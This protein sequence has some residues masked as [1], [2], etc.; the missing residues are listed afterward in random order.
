MK[1]RRAELTAHFEF[2]LD[3]FQLRALDALDDGQS[4]LVAA[5]TGSGKTVVA[6]YAIDA[7]IADGHRAFYTA[8][9]KALSNQKYHDLATRLGPQ[10]VGLLTGD[11]TING[12]APVVVMTT[13]VLRNMIYARSRSL[14]DLAMVVLDEVHFLQDAYR[15]PVWEE[16][17]IHLP[18]RVRLVCLSATVSNAAELAEWISTV[19]GP[20]SAIVEERRPVKLDNLYLIGDK[21][22]DRMHLLPTLVNGRMN[23]DAARLDEEAAR[24]AK[25]NRARRGAAQA[26]RRLFT[27]SRLEVVDLLEQHRMLPAIY[28]IFSRNQCDEAAKAAFAA[29]VRLTSGVERDRIREIV[30]ARLGAIDPADLAVLGYSTFLGQLEAGVAAHHAGMVPPFKE[31]VEACFV[32]GLVKVVFATETLAVGIN[33][34]AKTVVI[35]KLSKFTGDHHA[36]LT[37]GEYTQLTGR[38]GRRGMDDL[39]FAVVLWSPFVPFDQVAGLASSRTFHLNSAFRPT[40]NMAANL[41]HSY[42][43][44]QAHHMLNL[45]FAQYQADGDVV[46][47]EARLGRR[48]T[49]LAD[50]L[51]RARSPYGDI[52]EYRR[53]LK[54]VSTPAPGGA[55]GRDDLVSLALMKL[56]PGD[57]IYAEKARYAGRV[58]VLTSAH[59]KGGMRVTGL[60][61]RRDTVMLTAA[62]F[63]EPPRPLGRIELPIDYAP[64]RQDFQREVA[65]RLELATLAPHSRRGRKRSDATIDHTHPVEEDPD[66]DERLKAAAQAERVAR[67]V[68]E[69]RTRVRTRSQSVARDFDRVLRV[70]ENWGY[71]DGW[72]LT[73]AGRILARTFHECD[74]LI[75]ECLRQGL[76]D[77]LEPAHLA[78]LVSVFVYE[79]RSPEPAPTAWFPSPT[80]R[81]R[82]DRIAAISYELEEIE[83][84][85]GLAVHRPP[86]PTFVAVAFAWAAGEGFAEVV[87]AEELS[88]GD[89]VRTMK[90]LIDVLRQLALV[91]P[92][93]ATRHHAEQAA[94][95]LFRGVVAA[96]SA[97][98]PVDDIP[99]AVIATELADDHS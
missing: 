24:H 95:Q 58:A 23:N 83:E 9:I 3:D 53:Q 60:T 52:D 47:I 37:P 87:E 30:D 42:T 46:R 97:V 61:S 43:S 33:M 39:G 10:N 76:L 77:E 92:N 1:S 79:H 54:G 90:Q 69:L 63:D 6:E 73:E 4:V 74:L 44:E 68:E 16:V 88:G 12:D 26:R 5:P 14:N 45:S 98:E 13:E 27:P 71:V 41:V 48:Q 22:H 56:R 78:G 94:D 28:F 99:E 85:A 8:P 15:G 31:V 29:G 19:R 89:F 72:K 34:P 70:L 50:L 81:K 49:H 57:V 62:D 86:D 66:L 25:G 40:Y 36:F 17:I 82:W 93:K 75:V 35:E 51:E 59:R 21:T 2:P 84:E 65:H 91:A 32:E 96:S 7:A 80:V 38:A 64:N 55:V 20:T 18:A 67:E 11:N